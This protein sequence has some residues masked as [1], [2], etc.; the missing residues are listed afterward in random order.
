[1][2]QL[3]SIPSSAEIREPPQTFKGQLKYLGPG[4]IL[5]ASIVGSGE[6]IATT[7]LGAKAGF[8]TFWVILLS[9]LVKVTLQ[10]E[11]GKHAI[12]SGETTMASFNRLPGPRW[13][14]ANWSVWTWLFLMIFKFFQAGGIVGGVALVLH[15]AF[16][17]APVQVWTWLVAISVALIVFRGYYTLIEKL[18]VI[19]IGLFTILT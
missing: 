9:C 17:G 6:L 16:G 2:N 5:S 7:T 10:L 11:F 18:S 19:M 12:S 15:I 14:Q 8:V 3:N 13:G 4:F 1:M